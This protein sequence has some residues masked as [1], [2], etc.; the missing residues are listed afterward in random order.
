MVDNLPGKFVRGGPPRVLRSGMTDTWYVVTSYR[1]LGEG[2]FIASVKRPVHKDDAVGL[3]SAYQCFKDWEV[4]V[5]VEEGGLREVLGNDIEA[6]PRQTQ[7]ADP[8]FPETYDYETVSLEAV[9]ALVRGP[10]VE[11]TDD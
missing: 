3:E 10:A 7:H 5:L 1:D 4:G 11:V 2:K 8:F 9:L 6:L